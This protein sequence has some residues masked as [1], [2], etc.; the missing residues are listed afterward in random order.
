MS[1]TQAQSIA[2]LPRYTSIV[3]RI[4]WSKRMSQNLAELAET[5]IT[6]L[7]ALNTELKRQQ[8]EWAMSRYGKH[9]AGNGV[10]LSDNQM[11]E[12][13]TEIVDYDEDPAGTLQELAFEFEDDAG[14][15]EADYRYEE[16]RSRELLEGL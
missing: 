4:L 3:M 5:A 12:L 13:L 11:I 2:L 14:A 8:S 16:M 1:A 10:S 7:K 6:A 9:F 15:N